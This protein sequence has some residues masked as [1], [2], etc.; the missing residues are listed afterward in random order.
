[1]ILEDKLELNNIYGIMLVGEIKG[2]NT[3]RFDTES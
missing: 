2:Y 3:L 1:M